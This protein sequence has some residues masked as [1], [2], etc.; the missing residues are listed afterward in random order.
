MPVLHPTQYKTPV[1]QFNGHLQSIYPSIFRKVPFAYA[2]RERFELPDGDFVDLD[3]S[4]TQKESNKLVIITHGLE[5][6]S[7]RHYVRDG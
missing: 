6:D 1:L 5:G 4:V 3:W 7:T 2:R